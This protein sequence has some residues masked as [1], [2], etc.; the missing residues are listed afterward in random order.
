MCSDCCR[1]VLPGARTLTTT[2]RLLNTGTGAALSGGCRVYCCHRLS[3]PY[4]RSA[5]DHFLI[6]WTGN[7]GPLHRLVGFSPKPKDQPIPRGCTGKAAG[8]LTFSEHTGS[9][10]MRLRTVESGIYDENQL[11]DHTPQAFAFSDGSIARLH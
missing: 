7:F 6:T 9:S 11:T 4:W 5:S 10:T 8:R 1:W 2:K 3:R